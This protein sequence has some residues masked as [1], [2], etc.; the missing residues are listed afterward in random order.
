MLDPRQVSDNFDAIPRCARTPFNRSGGKP[1]AFAQLDRAS[2]S[3]DR[4]T[5]A[6]Q[7]ERNRQ[8]EAM[9]QL[10]KGP[11]KTAF[12]E[13]RE[14]LK[15]LSSEV[16]ELETQLAALDAEFETQLLHVPNTP[17]DSVPSGQGETDNPVVR[18]WG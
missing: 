5:E 3:A 6:K 2:S 18:V 9:A 15:V 14:Q 7:A 11:D 13:R 4:A 12:A 8:N 10:A 16:K 1:F 17:L